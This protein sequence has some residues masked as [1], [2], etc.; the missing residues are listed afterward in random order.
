MVAHLTRTTLKWDQ[1]TIAPI[2]R[3]SVVETEEMAFRELQEHQA[4][5]AGMGEMEREGSQ[6]CRDQKEKRE[7]KDPLG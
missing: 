6:G 4:K 2:L 5:M 3:Y 1:W 7:N